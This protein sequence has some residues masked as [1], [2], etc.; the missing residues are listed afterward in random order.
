MRSWLLALRNEP[1]WGKIQIIFY[2]AAVPTTGLVQPGLS[3]VEQPEKASEELARAYTGATNYRYSITWIG[4]YT[5]TGA[6]IQWASDN[7]FAAIDVE[8]PDYGEPDTIPNG[9]SETHLDIN[10]NGLLESVKT[11]IS[12]PGPKPWFEIRKHQ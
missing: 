2:H 11:A 4:A 7:G 12:S 10:L 6:A 5:V 9:W 3:Q 8:L 1:H